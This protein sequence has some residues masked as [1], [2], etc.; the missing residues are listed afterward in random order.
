MDSPEILAARADAEQARARLMA[1]IQ[2][3]QQRIAPRTLARDAWDGA[4][5]KGADIA[6]D[7]VD[8]VRRRPV[9]AGGLVAALALFLA[10][11]PL[12]DLAGKA[13]GTK[14]RGARKAEKKHAKVENEQ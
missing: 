11:E 5:S 14:K 13:I 7:A 2:E 9:A 8:A 1:T 6:E 12:M 3:L 4:R 10:R